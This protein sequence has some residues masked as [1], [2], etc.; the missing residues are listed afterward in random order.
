MIIKLIN[1]TEGTRSTFP[2]ITNEFTQVANW[3]T[4]T[5]EDVIKNDRGEKYQHKGVV[6]NVI[7]VEKVVVK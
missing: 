1:G 4:Y 6:N 5:N 7:L 3:N 2:D